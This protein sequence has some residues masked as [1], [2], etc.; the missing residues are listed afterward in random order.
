M[1]ASIVDTASSKH[2]GSCKWLISFIQ[3]FVCLFRISFRMILSLLISSPDEW[4]GSFVIR[5][6]LVLRP[7]F[8]CDFEKCPQTRQR[9]RK[10]CM[11]KRADDKRKSMGIVYSFHSYAAC[12]LYSG[13]T[14]VVASPTFKLTSEMSYIHRWWW[15]VVHSSGRFNANNVRLN[16]K[17]NIWWCAIGAAQVKP[18]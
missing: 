6:L 12:D 7:Q 11:N 16:V 17:S 1:R 2:H 18:N 13:D 9:C 5:L 14:R 3:F 10:R 8:E 15:D 4:Q